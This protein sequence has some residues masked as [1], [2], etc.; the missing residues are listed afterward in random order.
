MVEGVRPRTA[1]WKLADWPARAWIL[2]FWL[3]L[4]T[5]HRSVMAQMARMGLPAGA[6]PVEAAAWTVISAAAEVLQPHPHSSILRWLDG[7]VRGIARA[8]KIGGVALLMGL[9]AWGYAHRES[10]NGTDFSQMERRARLACAEGK[11]D[12]AAALYGQAARRGQET[13]FRYRQ[14]NEWMH[15]EQFGDAERAYRAL[16]AREPNAP[17]VRLNLALSVWRQGRLE[18]ALGLYRAFAEGAE[19]ERVPELVARAKLATDLIARQV[20][21][22]R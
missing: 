21:L 20:D 2:Y 7:H 19:A 5:P 9:M 22:D 12:R 6:S 13:Y 1:D 10:V 16:L 18:E 8:A 15:L 14:A 11:H 17:N 3:L 4:R